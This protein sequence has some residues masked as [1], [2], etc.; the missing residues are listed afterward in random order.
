MRARAPGFALVIVLLVSAGLFALALHAGV[1]M[2]SATVE[3]RVLL[4]RGSDEL[5]ARSAAAIVVA[6][7]GTSV[8]RFAAQSGRA[9]GTGAGGGSGGSGGDEPQQQV[10]I[11]A[12]IK[13]MIPDLDKVEAQARD[14]TGGSVQGGG[15][16][17][18]TSP[19]RAA[20]ASRFLSIPTRPIEV[21]L[22]E[23]RGRWRV[24]VRDALSGVNI[25]AAPQEQLTAYFVARGVEPALAGTLAAQIVDWRDED[26]F[27]LPGG[28]EQDAYTP[29]AI[30][31]R[32][33]PFANIEELLF[34]PAMSRE[35]LALVRHD[36]LTF[37]DGSVHVGSV[38]PEVLRTL[39][40]LDA[41]GAAV[42][43]EARSRG[44]LTKETLARLLPIRARD[45]AA[46]LR[47]EPSSLL[48]LRVEPVSGEGAAFEGA[49]VLAPD[50]TI[51]ALGL[52]P[53]LD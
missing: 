40:G 39:P 29:R 17:G 8:E 33:A 43:I 38:S 49:A 32:N 6:S 19:R 47:V 23:G 24:R 20:A 7:M 35:L 2:R 25:N 3:A 46:K 13:E 4:E 1:S 42:L 51:E 9:T 26:S 53:I 52:R 22:P 27:A 45:A 10:E 11:P 37:G 48:H 12:I 28:A 18:V 31:C 14:A 44:P 50:S 34:L 30:V 41:D 36:L 5:S 16:T 21:E 15:V